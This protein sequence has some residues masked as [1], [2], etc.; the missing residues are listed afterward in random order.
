MVRLNRI[1]QN[2][3][4]ITRDSVVRITALGRA[5]QYKPERE[6][7]GSWVMRDA[8]TCTYNLRC[9]NMAEMRAR[10]L[11]DYASGTISD[12]DLVK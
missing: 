5:V 4:S 6:S 10:L 9:C 12:V 8:N 7:D 1:Q 3:L 11:A 2:I